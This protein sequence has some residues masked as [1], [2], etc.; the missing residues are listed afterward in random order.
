MVQLKND[1]EQHLLGNLH[2]V[3]KT[4]NTLTLSNGNVYN[5]KEFNGALNMIKLMVQE[6]P[7]TLKILKEKV[8]VEALRCKLE[9]QEKEIKTKIEL[10]SSLSEIYNEK[11]SMIT[12]LDNITSHL[13][14]EKKKLQDSVTV[15]ILTRPTMSSNRF[16]CGYNDKAEFVMLFYKPGFKFNHSHTE[17]VKQY[18]KIAKSRLLDIAGGF[19][20]VERGNLHFTDNYNDITLFGHSDSYGYF[21]DMK[22][23]IFEYGK[24]HKVNF[25]VKGY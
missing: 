16:V 9:K 22:S 7:D 6:V 14:I 1:I 18:D 19:Y 13:E 24:T 10:L 2:V 11:T 20:H 12:R 21:Q 5:I 23:E 3:N 4:N 17:I 15:D 8:K 25:I